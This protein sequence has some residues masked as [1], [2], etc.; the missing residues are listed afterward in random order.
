MAFQLLNKSKPLAALGVL[1]TALRTRLAMLRTRLALVI[2]V[3]LGFVAFLV[4]TLLFGTE[5]VAAYY[6]R[7]QAAYEALD[8]YQELSHSAY[9]H[10]KHRMDL[11]LADSE[12]SRAEVEMSR[13]RLFA[14][15]DRLREAVEAGGRG[16]G[17]D[18]ERPPSL[19]SVAKL[20]AFLESG[21]YR[22]D[23]AEKLRQAGRRDESLALLAKI[24]KED[25]DRKFQPLIDSAI[26]D[27][28]E[29][30]LVARE[31][32]SALMD[33]LQW[34]GSLAGSIAAI[35]SIVAGSLL[36]RSIRRP[37]EALMRGTDEIASGNLDYRIALNSRDEF[38]YLSHH[39]DQMAEGLQEQ[40]GRLRDASTV[41]ERTVEERTR[42]LH[43]AI[44]EQRRMD[45]A[46]RQF[47]ADISH[48]L[49]TPLTVIRG[50]AEVT[51]RGRDKEADEYKETLERV[52]NLAMQLGKLVNDLLFLARAETANLQFEWEP[53]N[54]SALLEEITEDI[55]VLA[56][57]KAIAVS[58]ANS[59]EPAWVRGDR[60]RLRQVFFI[61][62]D[63]ACRYS[64]P[65]GSIAI[66]LAVG[67][68]RVAASF[69][70]Q[71]IGIAPHELELIFDRYYRSAHAR[72]SVEDG[73]GLGLPVAKTIV[74]AHNG[75]IAAAS[76]EEFGTTF[77]VTLPLL[78]IEST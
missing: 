77:T 71:G 22:F 68:G 58:F 40:Q 55:K 74:K 65:N 36:F 6:Q 76:G 7:T 64:K 16:G 57:D 56:D 37:I 17:A 49:R 52:R 47:F 33:K 34:I 4:M 43:Q 69:R 25:I 31:R 70:D 28:R 35:F 75:H 1:G 2:G 27:E 39:F 13:Q 41:L 66:R 59:P 15:L 51:L 5:Q 32:M 72:S 60:Q 14:A 30:A 45:D 61:L 46:R 38:G 67:D 48:E 10:F 9:R 12:A 54:L 21:M 63:N 42:Q 50:E 19:Q 18:A 78:Q 23:E 24:L 3:S 20:T 29:Q 73:S 8:R 26:A 44:E 11:H 53:V 62:G